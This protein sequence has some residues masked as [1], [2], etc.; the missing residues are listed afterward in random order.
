[1]AIATATYL[2]EWRPA[3]VWTDISSAVLDVRGDDAITLSPDNALAFGDASEQRASVTTST[4]LAATSWSRTPIR[5]TYTINGTARLAFAGIVTGRRRRGDALEFDCVGFAELLRATKAYSAAL[6]RRPV[7]TKTSASSVEDPDDPSWQAGLINWILWQAG[8]RPSEQSG[9]YPSATFYYSCDQAALAPTWSWAAGEDGWAELQ[10]LAEAGGGQIF[11]R[12]DGVV[13]YRQPYG[14]PD[15]TA[16]YTFDESVY[17]PDPSEAASASKVCTAVRCSYVQRAERP[18]QQVADDTTARLIAIG[19]SITV[20]LEPSWPITSLETRGGS[21]T[22]TAVHASMGIEEAVQG[23]HYTTVVSWSAQQV[24]VGINNSSGYP[25]SVWSITLRGTPIMPIESGSVTIGSGV[26]QRA[27][28]DNPYIQDEAHARRLCQL[29]LLYYGAPRPVRTI[30]RC[31]Y[32]PLRAVGEAVR[33][34]I[35]IWSISSQLHLIAAI[36]H[37]ATGLFADYDLIPIDDLPTAGDYFQVGTAYSGL[38][39]K[40][41]Y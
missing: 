16:T 31:V 38:S 37:D 33:L 29:Y 18:L 35:G 34:T 19:E 21:L 11:Q 32:D 7:A 25:L 5:I 4:A 15:G 26:N 17:G 24:T 27:V 13:C 2:V 23:T 14:Y 1:M 6:E 9:S 12:G 39:R 3:G 41:T 40:L 28:Q 30:A 22:D 20:V 10:K 36:R 8:G